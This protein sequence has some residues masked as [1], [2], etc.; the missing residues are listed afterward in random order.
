[1]R[2]CGS[3]CSLI[4]ATEQLGNDVP[5]AR[6]GFVRSFV[7]CEIRVIS[8]ESRQLFPELLVY[9]DEHTDGR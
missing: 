2:V 8:K 7:L 3:L 1:M 6:R 4:V 5:A 9:R